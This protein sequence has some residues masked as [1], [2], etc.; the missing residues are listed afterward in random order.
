MCVVEPIQTLF[1]WLTCCPHYLPPP[2]HSDLLAT[3]E[4]L[5]ER[6]SKF[7]YIIIETSGMADPG[8]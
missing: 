3:L 5:V 1:T 8:K 4:A 7:D 2:T 6:K